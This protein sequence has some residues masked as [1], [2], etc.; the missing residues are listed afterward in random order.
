MLDEHDLHV[1]G[2]DARLV[3]GSQYG[4]ERGRPRCRP[5]RGARL[6]G[7][8]SAPQW[9]EIDPLRKRPAAVLNPGLVAV[10][11]GVL[12][13]ADDQQPTT[14][15]CIVDRKRVDGIEGVTGKSVPAAQLVGLD[16]RN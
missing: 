11:K 16:I 8:Q 15:C 6:P 10:D 14:R 12:T 5:R 1:C 4:H 7:F 2:T 13:S 9:V 3:R